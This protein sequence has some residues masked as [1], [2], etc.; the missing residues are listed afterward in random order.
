MIKVQKIAKKFAIALFAALL[1]TGISFIIL[2][3]LINLFSKSFMDIRDFYNPLVYLFPKNYTLFNYETALRFLDYG[4]SLTFSM[5]FVLIVTV[6]QAFICS[7]VGYGFA[8]FSF[9]LKNVLFAF[10][11]LTIVIPPQTFM[12]RMYMQFRYFDI[13]NIISLVR[14]D[15]LNLLNTPFPILILTVF[16][17]GLRSGLYIYM[18]RQFFRGL[19]KEI[20]EAAF[21]DGAG[22]LYTYFRVML[23]NAVP[24][25]ITVMLFSFVWQFNDTFYSSTF[26]MRYNFMSMNLSSVAGNFAASVG[27][28]QVDP[29]LVTLVTYAAVLLA[30]APIV[31]IYLVLQRYF[32]E[33]I[34]R[35]GIVG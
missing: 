3:P 32:I 26:M 33:G 5:I 8:R 6:L 4:T 29:N 22:K 35:S 12:L 30:I 21:I 31:L 15:S 11:I 24:S 28:L 23:P 27:T 13:F 17:M 34:E 18:F 9:P 1:L 20:E 2:S 10:V 14:G 16:G 25:L 19:P 7:L